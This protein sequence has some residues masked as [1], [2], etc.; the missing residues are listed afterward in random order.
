MS[1]INMIFTYGLIASGALPVLA[2]LTLPKSGKEQVSTL[3]I[4]WF[5]T[6]VLADTVAHVAYVYL[7]LNVYPVFHVS[8]C[9]EFT[10]L[11][12]YFV[13][14]MGWNRRPLGW[15]LT[16]IPLVTFL[17]EITF[18]N[19]IFEL[20]EISIAAYFLVIAMLYMSLM[21]NPSKW[22]KKQLVIILSFFI[23]HA[24]LAVFGVF[25][26]E[27]R[28]NFDLFKFIYPFFWTANLVFNLFFAY[29]FWTFRKLEKGSVQKAT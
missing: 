26:T 2:Y 3:I 23:Y 9:I 10:L 12:L 19:S 15:I 1:T 4:A 14:V 22:N 25:Q 21:F 27:M 17:V 7:N 13:N 28:T 18:V 6:R 8:I 29:Y 20:E 16:S 5:A 24:F 11:M